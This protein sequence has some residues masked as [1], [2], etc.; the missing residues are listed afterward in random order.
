M[1][2]AHNNNLHHIFVVVV[3]CLLPCASLFITEAHARRALLISMDFFFV[4]SVR[5]LS[6]SRNLL[7]SFV[8]VVVVVVVCNI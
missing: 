6:R 1:Y 3:L 4:H 2:P 8:N 7:Y 5:F